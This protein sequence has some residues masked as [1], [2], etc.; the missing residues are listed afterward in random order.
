MARGFAHRLFDHPPIDALI[1]PKVGCGLLRQ[2]PVRLDLHPIIRLSIATVPQQ[3]PAY[4]IDG[5]RKQIQTEVI[6]Y[7]SDIGVV[8]RATA[9]KADEGVG[10]SWRATDSPS[11]A[12]DWRKGAPTPASFCLPSPAQSAIS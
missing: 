3:W 10:V 2:I 8:N 5:W 1:D 9:R 11:S 12:H 7:F 6:Q 4:Q